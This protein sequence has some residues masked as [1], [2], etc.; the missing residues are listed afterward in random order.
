[1]GSPPIAV[2]AIVFLLLL[3]S[4]QVVSSWKGFCPLACYDPRGPTRRVGAFLDAKDA[5]SSIPFCPFPS[6][7]LPHR[8]V[9][10]VGDAGCY[11][12][13]PEPIPGPSFPSVP[14]SRDLQVISTISAWQCLQNDPRCGLGHPGQQCDVFMPCKTLSYRHTQTPNCNCLDQ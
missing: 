5:V 7:L 2:P 1:M 9:W 13:G 11:N 14:A 3:V 6:S 10:Q 4:R 8:G 12:L